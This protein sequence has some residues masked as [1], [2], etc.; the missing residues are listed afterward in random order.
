[1]KRAE[2]ILDFDLDPIPKYILM[3]EIL[4]LDKDSEEMIEARKKVFESDM[5]TEIINE[6]W[7]DGSWGNFHSM[8]ELRHKPITTEQAI[9]RLIA[10]GLDKED[11]VIHK[12]LTYMELYLLG[13]LDL[14]DHKEKKHDWDLYSK[15]IVATWIRILD[16]FN[17][18]AKE[19]AKDWGRVITNA[20]HGD[21]YDHK[22]YKEAYYYVH[23]S[24]EEKEMLGFQN[25]YVISILFDILS[26]EIEEKFLDYIINSQEGIYYIYD[27]SLNHFPDDFHSKDAT[28]IINA[29]ELL[30]NYK[31]A[32]PKMKD[33]LKWLYDN[34][35]RDGFWD[36]GQKSKD[37]IHLPLSETWR[38]PINRKIDCTV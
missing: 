21:K 10:L 22:A 11:E 27:E 1:M 25:F 3:N 18:T 37:M 14:R 20:F 29:Y 4:E 34:I 12:A 26:K 36:M 15:L 19:I 35:C 17:I 28:R 23:K 31:T 6:Q 5:I 33:F 30:S 8:A 2:Q 24:P 13:E 7:D 32:K 9:R 38:K 16:P